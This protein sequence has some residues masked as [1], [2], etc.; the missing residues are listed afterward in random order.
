[1]KGSLGDKVRLRHILDAINEVEQ[2]LENVS[3]TLFL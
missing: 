3:Y 2:Y 1:M